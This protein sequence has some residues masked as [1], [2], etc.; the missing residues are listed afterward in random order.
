M[1]IDRRNM[2]RQL[3][4]RGAVD[5]RARP[6]ELIDRVTGAASGLDWTEA[7]DDRNRLRRCPVCGCRDLFRRKDA[8]QRL[9]LALVILAVVASIVLF[10][11]HQVAWSLLVLVGMVIVDFMVG[12]FFGQCLVCYRCRSEFRDTMVDPAVHHPWDLAIGEKY[13]RQRIGMSD[14]VVSDHES[15]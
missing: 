7:V 11:R 10:A 5:P 15:A 13:R 3:T 1:L 2:A 9:G 4:A 6:T 12:C 14:T 8:P